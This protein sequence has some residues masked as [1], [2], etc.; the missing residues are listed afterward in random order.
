MRK[1]ERRRVGK[2]KNEFEVE[3]G[4]VWKE[5]RAKTD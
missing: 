5:T 1:K 4:E 2:K 3:E